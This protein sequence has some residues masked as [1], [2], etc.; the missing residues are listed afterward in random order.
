MIDL[1]ELN[2][3]ESIGPTI[4]RDSRDCGWHHWCDEIDSFIPLFNHLWFLSTLQFSQTTSENANGRT[5]TKRNETKRVH[6]PLH[7]D[8]FHFHVAIVHRMLLI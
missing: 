4:N 8:R 5:E 1:I 3:M 2:G 6:R 7:S